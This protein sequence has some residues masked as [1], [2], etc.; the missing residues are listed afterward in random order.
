V[1][2]NLEQDIA[3]AVDALN[4]GEIVAYPTEAVYGLG[5]DPNN[6]EAIERLI[7]LKKRNP[8]KGLILIASRFEQLKPFLDDIDLERASRAKSQWPGPVTWVWPKNQQF[9][10]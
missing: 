9:N 5:C 1:R 4:K 7:E 8:D 2:I 10:V 6:A 3:E